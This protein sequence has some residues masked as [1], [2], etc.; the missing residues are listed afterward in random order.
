MVQGEINNSPDIIGKVENSLHNVYSNAS[1]TS[2]V[3][4]DM[5]KVYVALVIGD[6]DNVFFM[7]GHRTD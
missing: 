1:N 7:K 4:Y 3:S 2:S 6:G 5:S